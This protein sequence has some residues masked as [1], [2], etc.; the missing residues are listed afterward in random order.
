[1]SSVVADEGGAEL[2]A[3]ARWHAVSLTARL[4]E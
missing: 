4:P 2:I 3:C 1:M